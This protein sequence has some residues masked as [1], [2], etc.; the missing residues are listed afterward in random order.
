MRGLGSPD[1]MHDVELVLDAAA[2]LGEGPTWDS[3]ARVLIWVDITGC[4]VHRFDP[5]TGRDAAIDVGRPVG[6]AVPTT[7]GRLA[8]ALSDRFSLLDPTT[9]Q[10][11]LLAEVE[12]DVAE[13]IMNDGKCDP[14][15]RFWAGTK[16]V[17]GYRPLGSLYRLGTDRGPVQV[18]TG[19]TLSNGLGWS[20]D[21]RTMYYID[22]P[23]YAVDAFDFEPETGSV[24][25]RRRL[26]GFPKGWGLP[27][28]MTVDE[29]GFLWVAFWGGS[30][31]RRIAPDGRITAAVV[32]PVSQVTSCAFGGDDLA[33]LY[34]TSARTGLSD[35]QLR[36]EPSAGG[37]FRLRPGVHGLPHTPSDL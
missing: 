7:S 37:L 33:D 19:V 9:G 17:E 5:A 34:A 8:L 12:A 35:D 29:E 1:V 10:T 36:E 18:L 2:D 22:S 3:R 25:H 20:P 6:A 16:D 4:R 11:E 31:V 26:V 30:T 24:S 13:T 28:G 32:F 15:G 23:T 21:G 14:A 27:D